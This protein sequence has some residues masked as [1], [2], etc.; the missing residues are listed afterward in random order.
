MKLV[1][2]VPNFS[3]GRRK[4]VIDAVLSASQSVK[5][6]KV[7]DCESDKDHNRMVLTLVGPPDKIKQS[8]LAACEVAI[9]SI[10]L[11][12]H[13]GEHPRMGAVDVVPFVPL[14][15][16]SLEEC[17]DLAKSFASE[18]SAKFGVPVFLY[19]AAAT[20]PD[21]KD[22]SQIRKGQ[23]E[24]LRELIGKD[25]SKDPDFGPKSIHPTAGATAVGARQILIAYNVNLRST[26]L[27]IAK[28]IAR[29]VRGRD[30][31]LTYVKALGFELK[32]RE[33]VQVSM[34]LTDYKKSSIYKAFELVS[35]LAKRYGVE[36][37]QSE[38][39]GL[40]PMDALI[41]V[42]KYFLKLDNFSENQIIE[43]RIYGF[44]SQSDSQIN[45][46]DE[47]GDFSDMTLSEFAS[48]VSS[49]EPI[50]GG[51]S[52][53]AYV[54]AL[55]ASLAAM[56][57]RLTIGKKGYE[58]VQERIKSILSS[59]IEYSKQLQELVN[60]D[61][62]AYMLVMQAS[63]LAK[64]NEEEREQRSEKLKGALKRATEVPVS[65]LKLSS[66]VL[67]LAEE[68]LQIGNR[69]ARSDVETAI[70]LSKAAIRSAWSNVKLNL[71]SL[72]DETEYVNKI[73]ESVNPI[74]ATI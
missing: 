17:V 52:V 59:L 56:V 31:G 37:A 62:N 35:L 74:L 6:V 26:D 47:Q 66:K 12:K 33:M 19:E 41:D 57:C 24:G 3:E 1:E 2:S 68:I 20:R 22:L 11:T 7:L 4:E 29:E 16:T 69:N 25:P 73:K 8:V 44:L 9:R 30:G 21:R 67:K 58:Q 40:V 39:V 34:N 14:G 15:E 36:V 55:A 43:N 53:S 50:P 10:D 54:G 46:D 42:S 45:H 71:E 32:E 60:E 48:C 23:F 64:Q 70:E 49:S 5:G 13:V 27:S 63:K 28:K 72:A 18:F 51:G 65:T 38:I 61:A